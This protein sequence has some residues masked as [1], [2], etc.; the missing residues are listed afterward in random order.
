[1]LSVGFLHDPITNFDACANFCFDGLKAK[2]I[3]SKIDH[4]F[5]PMKSRI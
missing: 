5:N 4:Y 3:I 1:M 2:V